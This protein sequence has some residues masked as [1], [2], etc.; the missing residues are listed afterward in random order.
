MKPW[1]RSASVRRLALAVAAVALLAAGGAGT[2]KAATVTV[3]S[4]LTETP[5]GHFAGSATEVNVALAEPGARVASPVNGTIVSYRVDVAI[6]GEFAIR[7]IRPAGGGAYTGIASS[8]RVTPSSFGLQ[9]FSANVPIQ[10]GDL[11][12]LDLG[13]DAG[14]AQANVT[15]STVN[16]WGNAGFLADGET[17]P[18][19]NTY[20]NDELLFNAEVAASNIVTVGATQRNKKKGT[21]ILTLSLPNPG[22]LTAGGTGVTVVPVGGAVTSQSVGAGDV[23]LLIT[24]TGKKRKKL[25]AK[26]KVKVAVSLTY[27]PTLGDPATQSVQLKLKKKLK[28]RKR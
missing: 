6:L 9:S 25:K 17:A 1:E 14:V 7:T 15:G 27:T 23:Q 2:A 20:P 8:T 21:A 3:G 19:K 10:A 5:L 28:K 18:P 24:T 26:G 16:E 4:P 12:G 22:E 11:V 13:E